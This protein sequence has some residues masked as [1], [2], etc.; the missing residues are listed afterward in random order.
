MLFHDLEKWEFRQST[1]N[2]HTDLGLNIIYEIFANLGIYIHVIIVKI[3]YFI[4]TLKFT[5]SRSPLLQLKTMN[6]SYQTRFIE[7]TTKTCL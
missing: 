6:N 4:S 2:L 1:S 5:N 3:K 7:F